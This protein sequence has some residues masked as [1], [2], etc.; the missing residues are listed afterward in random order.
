MN[1]TRTVFGD[2]SAGT[3][4]MACT[5]GTV[6]WQGATLR[7]A[8]TR[9]RA[10]SAPTTTSAC[11]SSA[12]ASAVRSMFRRSPVPL[13]C[14]STNRLPKETFAPLPR[15][16][17]ARL[18]ISRDLSIIRSGP[19]QRLLG[20]TA[21]GEQFKFAD[22]VDD[23]RLAELSQQRAHVTGHDQRARSGIQLVGTFEH[24]DRA[25]RTEPATRP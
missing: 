10:P 4:T 5:R 16:S 11:N 2:M 9:E 20:A 8:P 23:R 6:G 12:R 7:L 13:L 1:Q 22:F 18:R 14:K 3:F 17:S 19:I 25:A 24:F 15:A 21:I